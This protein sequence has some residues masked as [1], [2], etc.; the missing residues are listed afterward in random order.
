MPVPALDGAPEVIPAEPQDSEVEPEELDSQG[1]RYACVDFHG[2]SLKVR[3]LTG[4][5]L[6]VIRRLQKLLT[7]EHVSTLTVDQSVALLDRALVGFT[8]MIVNPEDVTFIE[9][10][11]LARTITLGDI[12]PML[13]EA[14]EAVKIA[15]ADTGSREQ[16]RAATQAANRAGRGSGVAALDVG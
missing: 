15:N 12:S 13:A 5:Q 14:I 10:L 1:L 11:L 4:E 2:R 7:A 3:M 6:V 16:R 9:D 8:T